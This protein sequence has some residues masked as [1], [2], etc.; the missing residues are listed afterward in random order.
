MMVRG[1]S[2]LVVAVYGNVVNVMTDLIETSS[3]VSRLATDLV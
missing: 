2:S 1:R 3:G